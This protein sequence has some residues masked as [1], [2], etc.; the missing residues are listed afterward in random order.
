MH[1]LGVAAPPILVSLC[2]QR[3]PCYDYCCLLSTC[4]HADCDRQS[5]QLLNTLLGAP[6]LSTQWLHSVVVFADYF[7]QLAVVTR[8]C[9]GTLPPAWL[10][11]MRSQQCWCRR[12]I[13]CQRHWWRCYHHR[14]VTVDG[15]APT[16]PYLEVAGAGAP[17]LVLA[18][19]CTARTD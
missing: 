1:V 17:C 5:A 7:L 10:T 13:P 2:E 4:N 9:L 15:I 18:G 16:H 19:T 14:L 12:W 6:Y 11:L 3:S 8:T